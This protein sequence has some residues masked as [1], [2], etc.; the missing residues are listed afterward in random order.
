M[1]V[2]ATRP[3]S[4]VT[5]ARHDPRDDWHPEARSLRAHL[6][7]LY[8]PGDPLP[9]LAGAWINRQRSPHTRRRYARQ[10]RVWDE[11]ARSCGIHPLTARLPLADAYAARLQTAP[12]LRRIRKGRPTD[13][14]PIGPPARATTRANA[15][16]AVSS[17]Y[18]YALRVGKVEANPFAGVNRPKVN[19]DHSTTD[20]MLPEETDRLMATAR[21]WSPRSHALVSLLYLLGLRIDELL[22]LDAD[23]LGYDTGHRV[24]P[25]K[26]K[27]SEDPVKVPA[28]PAALDALLTYLDGRTTGPLFTTASGKRW[29]QPQ[30]WKHLRVL[31][32]HAGIPQAGVI[33][34]HTLRHGFITD[35]LEAKV[36]LHI[37]QD[38]A[39]HADPRTTQRYNRRRGL[40]DNH[41]THTLA[42]RM[43][44]RA[45]G[46]RT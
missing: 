25:I 10:F 38:A 18:T 1:T 36:P 9:T 28:P 22:A 29:T 43:A 35:A 41:P 19:Q 44:E 21:A 20:G 8:A 24:L 7:A 32:R 27:G 34:P 46:A 39:G 3:A 14:A 37:V 23:R 13:M 17:F 42:L 16:S 26:R 11:Y 31:A 5:T 40:L 6:E 30:V 15:L 33:H 2:L 12:T 45:A 4:E